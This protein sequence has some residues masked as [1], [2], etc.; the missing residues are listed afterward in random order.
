MAVTDLKNK[1]KGLAGDVRRYWKEPQKGRY[2][3]FKEI[4]AYSFGGIGAYFIIQLGSTLIVSTTNTIVNTAIGVAPTDGYIIYLLSTLLNIPLTGIRANM[5]DNTR[6]KGGK[7]RPYLLSMGIPTAL[8]ALVYVNSY[9]LQPAASLFLL[10]LPG[11][12]HKPYSRSFAKHSGKNR[13]FIN[14]IYCVF[15]CPLHNE[16]C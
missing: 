2:M 12:I 10:F 13:C 11:R 1:A 6:G 8:V 16:H 14:Q 3:P 9:R 5:V 15:S 4:F 7:Y